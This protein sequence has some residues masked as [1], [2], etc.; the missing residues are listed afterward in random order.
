MSLSDALLTNLEDWAKYKGTNLL[1]TPPYCPD[2]QPIE[3]VW[4][5]VKGRVAREWTKE[6]TLREAF[7]HLCNAFYGGPT[8]IKTMWKPISGKLCSKL[9]ERSLLMAQKRLE[10][11]DLLSGSLQ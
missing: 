4:A 8:R 2:L 3:L 11:D 10:F 9:I 5:I 7:G 1:F 6:R